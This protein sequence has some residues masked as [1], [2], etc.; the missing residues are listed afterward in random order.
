MNL[1]FDH[2]VS[3]RLRKHLSP[4]RVRLTREEGWNELDNGDLLAI[5]QKEF[6]VLLTNDTNIYH[7]QKVAA[8]DIS[9][10]VLRAFNNDYDS[11]V[12]LMDDVLQTIETL[13]PG[14]VVYL[15]AADKPKKSDQRRGK[16]PFAKGRR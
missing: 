15:Y 13:Q 3:R 12:C 14:Q 8:Y 10:I 1:L 4:H 16:G 2:N 9:V 7:Q 6:D 5:A 11:L